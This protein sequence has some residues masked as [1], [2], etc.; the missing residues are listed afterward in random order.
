MALDIES[1]EL[2][3][4]FVLVQGLNHVHEDDTRVK[5]SLDLIN[6]QYE[7]GRRLYLDVRGS[8]SEGARGLTDLS[9]R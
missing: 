5:R 7:S 4:P 2:V 6:S 9:Q 8:S 1:K 3:L